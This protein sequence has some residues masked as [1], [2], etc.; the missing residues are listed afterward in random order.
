M[1]LGDGRV[2]SEEF[3]DAFNGLLTGGIDAEEM[4]P[5]VDCQS[6]FKICGSALPDFFL[7]I[8]GQLRN[9]GVIDFI[10]Y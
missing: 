7:Q 4:E 3:V 5:G 6:F 1:K 10:E 9:Y 2:P 8:F